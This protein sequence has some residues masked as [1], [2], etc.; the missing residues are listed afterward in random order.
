[1]LLWPI[2]KQLSSHC[3]VSTLCQPQ[4]Q[5]FS[6]ATRARESTSQGSRRRQYSYRRRLR[7]GHAAS[8][9]NRAPVAGRMDAPC[10]CN[11]RRHACVM[12]AVVVV[13]H[14]QLRGETRW[15]A[16]PVC[17]SKSLERFGAL[18]ILQMSY[19]RVPKCTGE[20]LASERSKRSEC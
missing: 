10:V 15:P 17:E 6:R 14:V 18:L 3:D 19:K 7:R 1:M 8:E 4:L 9:L 12:L 16:W 20:S 2:G 13:E 5:P 11:R